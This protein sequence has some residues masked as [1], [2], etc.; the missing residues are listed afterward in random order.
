[1]TKKQLGSKIQ[2]HDQTVS[3]KEEHKGYMCLSSV[4][5]RSPYSEKIAEKSNFL[6]LSFFIAYIEI[7]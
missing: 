1:M 6:L 4:L 5:K 2:S 3:N 7:N